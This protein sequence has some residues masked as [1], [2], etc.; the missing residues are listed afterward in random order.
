MT[1]IKLI[2]VAFGILAMSVEVTYG[3]TAL[4]SSANDK[5]Q[6]LGRSDRQEGPHWQEAIE[7]CLRKGPCR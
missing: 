2:V 7:A 5:V 6:A 4:D 1:A 3:R